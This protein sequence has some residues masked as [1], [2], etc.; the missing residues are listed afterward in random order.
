MPSYW[1]TEKNNDIPVYSPHNW[2]R[3]HPLSLYIYKKKRVAHNYKAHAQIINVPVPQL[4]FQPG[5]KASPFPFIH[6]IASSQNHIATW[7][8]ESAELITCAKLQ[9][10]C[11]SY[12]LACCEVWHCRHAMTAVTMHAPRHTLWWSCTWGRELQISPTLS[13]AS[14]TPK[15]ATVITHII[16]HLH[17]SALFRIMLRQAPTILFSQSMFV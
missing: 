4:L 15:N 12:P 2:L 10:L 14:Y 11:K 13:G 17:A 1:A 16:L 5:A 6:R 7:P 9:G 8:G 3:K